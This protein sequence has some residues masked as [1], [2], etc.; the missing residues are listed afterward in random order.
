MGNQTS[1]TSLDIGH[2]LREA[3]T[4]FQR[5]RTYLPGSQFQEVAAAFRLFAARLEEGQRAPYWVAQA[6]R[7][8]RRATG[9]P[10]HHST[11]RRA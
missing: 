6:P 5:F 9:T 3:T 4:T 8:H 7:R 11:A 2:Q 10:R 1:L